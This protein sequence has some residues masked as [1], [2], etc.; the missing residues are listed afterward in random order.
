MVG[1]ILLLAWSRIIASKIV[2]PLDGMVGHHRNLT[3]KFVCS[4]LA[5]IETTSQRRYVALHITRVLDH[6]TRNLHIG[7]SCTVPSL[8][9]LS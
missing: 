8:F 6:V 4:G 3:T 5:R 2:D 1:N 7:Y 9:H